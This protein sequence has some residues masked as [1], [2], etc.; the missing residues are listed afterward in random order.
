MNIEEDTDEIVLRCILKE[1]KSTRQIAKELNIP[2][3]RVKVH[4]FKLRK[5]REVVKVINDDGNQGRVGFKFRAAYHIRHDKK[6][7]NAPK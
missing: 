1:Y 4:I 7:A 5:H 2:I 6:Y 3:R